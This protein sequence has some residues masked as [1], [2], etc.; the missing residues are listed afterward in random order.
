MTNRKTTIPASPDLQGFKIQIYI[1]YTQQRL[2]RGGPV[3]VAMQDI[4]LSDL[5]AAGSSKAEAQVLHRA[6]LSLAI[7]FFGSQHNSS[8]IMDLGYALYGLVLKQLNFALSDPKCYVRD[9]VLLSVVTLALLEC[10]IPT[11]RKYY[12]KHM[13]GLERLLELRGPAMLNSPKSFHIYMSI[14]RMITAASLDTRRP[15][16]FAREEWKSISQTERLDEK[17]ED[18]PFYDVLADCTVLLAERD[19]VIADWDLGITDVTHRRDKVFRKALH[20]LDRLHDWKRL[21]DMDSDNVHFGVLA[22][23]IGPQW[24]Q[25]IRE[26]SSLPF[27][28]VFVFTRNVAAVMFMLYNT[29]L[30][31]ILQVLAS[32]LP[33]NSYIH[34]YPTKT[35]LGDSDLSTDNY[36]AAARS[37]ALDI[38]R[39]N[40]F[41]LSRKSSMDTDSLLATHLAIRT[42]WLTLDGNDSREG[43]WMTDLLRSE[44][45]EVFAEGLWVD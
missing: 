31:Y 1:C 16:I 2:F 34:E 12:F 7:I 40:P 29:S 5:Y 44:G 42:A 15:C 25:G 8:S 35:M 13:F 27:P 10:F 37:A 11:G 18:K 32:L 28:T 17:T 4:Q 38:F 41:G 6:I 33:E 21:W 20:L 14:R 24:L 22:E 36:V 30:I 43:R 26:R 45:S 3:D 39:C 19:K 9:D 23:S